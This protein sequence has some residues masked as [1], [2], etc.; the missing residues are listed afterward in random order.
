MST[1]YEPLNVF[2]CLQVELT[3]SPSPPI[4]TWFFFV[5]ASHRS[6]GNW[7]RYAMSGGGYCRCSSSDSRLQAVA[8]F[9]GFSSL[10]LARQD[11]PLDSTH[12]ELGAMWLALKRLRWAVVRGLLGWAR[13]EVKLLS[14]CEAVENA[15]KPDGA[16]VSSRFVPLQQGEVT[17]MLQLPASR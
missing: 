12:A 10:L 11:I 4:I 3:R 5:D 16:S 2:C 7:G 17:H 6:R 15:L 8:H 13:H 14:D 1:C 9:L